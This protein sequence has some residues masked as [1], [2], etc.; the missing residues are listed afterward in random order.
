M[1]RKIISDLDAWLIGYSG[2]MPS[3]IHKYATI[4]EASG[5]VSPPS[6]N[7][8]RVMQSTSVATDLGMIGFTYAVGVEGTS[9][10]IGGISRVLTGWQ[11]SRFVRYA[12]FTPAMITLGV[13]TIAL[14]NWERPTRTYTEYETG[15]STRRQLTLS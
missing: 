9:S 11:M 2:F 5:R 13:V 14:S 3:P 10:Q 15:F 4:G 1:P 8:W 7:E 12:R 6:V